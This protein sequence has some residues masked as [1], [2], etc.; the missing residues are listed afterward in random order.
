MRMGTMKYAKHMPENTSPARAPNDHIA[1]L[2]SPSG[3]FAFFTAKTRQ[4]T[5]KMTPIPQ[6][7]LKT[8]SKMLSD[9]DDSF[10]KECMIPD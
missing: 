2:T 5:A 8:A 10:H 7:A 6:S 4:M 9:R 3:L 1:I